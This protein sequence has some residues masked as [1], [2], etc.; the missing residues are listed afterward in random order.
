[1]KLRLMMMVMVRMMVMVMVMVMMMIVMLRMLHCKIEKD[2]AACPRSL[3]SGSC[4]CDASRTLIKVEH[5][6]SYNRR[7]K[8]NALSYYSIH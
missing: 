1:M 8:C 5:T 7:R 3:Q 2:N 4:N 6:T